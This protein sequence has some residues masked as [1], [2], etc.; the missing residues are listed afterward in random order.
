MDFC[1]WQYF[2][3][4]A[5]PDLHVDDAHCCRE[6]GNYVDRILSVDEAKRKNEEELKV[7]HAT[8][9]INN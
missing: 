3:L 9:I 4:L 8:F 5:V 2:A 6:Y 7:I 1:F